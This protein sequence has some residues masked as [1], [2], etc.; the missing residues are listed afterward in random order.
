MD[1]RFDHIIRDG[2][3]FESFLRYVLHNP[4]ESG[5]VDRADEYDAVRVQD[6]LQ[7]LLLKHRSETGATRRE[8]GDN[9]LS[10][11]PDRYA[12]TYEAWHDGLRDWCISRQLW[13][14][15]R[16]PVWTRETGGDV[17]AWE[18]REDCAVAHTEHHVHVCPASDDDELIRRLEEEGFVRDPDVLDTWFSSA[19]WPL[20]TMGWPEGDRPIVNPH[21][22][23]PADAS[24]IKSVW[25][26]RVR[27]FKEFIG[28]EGEY[29]G[30][31][32]DR[33]LH[34][35][36]NATTAD[37]VRPIAYQLFR[38][39]ELR[40]EGVNAVA[41]TEPEDIQEADDLVC[42]VGIKETAPVESTKFGAIHVESLLLSH[43]FTDTAGLLDAFNPSTVL[44]TGRDIIT[45][46]VSRMVM[47]NRYFKGGDLPFRDVYINPIV[48]DG[49]GQR[50]SKS[51]GNGVDPLDIVHSH[52][53]DALRIVLCQIAT[54]TQ[55]VRMPVDT[56]CPHTG[57]VFEP[58]TTVTGAGRVV[59]APIQ[60]SPKNPSKKMVT[61]YGVASGLAEATDETP[62][63]RNTSSRFDAGRNICTK[64]WNATR[65]G[66][67]NLEEVEGSADGPVSL[68]D[69]SLV[70][71]WM[72]GRLVRAVEEID[73]A[74]ATYQ[75]ARYADL[76]YDLFWRDFCDWYLEAVK[77]TLRSDP[78]QRAV[79]RAAID[80]ILRV[81]HPITP[82]I[83][84]V[85]YEHL[86]GLP[87]TGTIDGLT[88]GASELLC[89]APWPVVDGSLY[90]EGV[91]A[92][93]QE[94]QSLVEAIRQLRAQ[95]NITFKQKLTLHAPEP[96]V[97]LV[98]DAGEVVPTLAGLSDVTTDAPEGASVELLHEGVS[99]R[100]SG[101]DE[102]VDPAKLRS[103]LAD[104]EKKLAGEIRGLEGRL[105]NPGYVNKAP[106]HLVEETKGQLASKQ[107]ER[108]EIEQRL[109]DLA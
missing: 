59:A 11:S 97:A 58:E 81:F 49:H 54:A 91:G 30:E 75:F 98:R 99:L 66:M 79:F 23:D 34:L 17:S 109:K 101:L 82:F 93:W 68:D 105:N 44:C 38:E 83:T 50:M 28:T 89:T 26:K 20:S 72:L 15:H 18:Q 33:L 42:A 32:I 14:G 40:A 22:I 104:R 29:S 43:G 86:R 102:G 5:L 62:L 65:F 36:D 25:V 13:W 16:I 57:E 90:D 69:A 4:V 3:W 19:L 96:I 52:G 100:L 56:V 107:A 87:Q 92:R 95:Q 108:A 88:L 1:E 60:T 27:T 70:D 10:F 55:D 45:L 84:E 2:V 74:I 94:V 37:G 61:A 24:S 76:V 85:L 12:K 9:G 64:L 80:V 51:L 71:R 41:L 78:V 77:P 31:L 47:F 21:Q 8:N 53:A 73:E 106:A 7:S 39:A 103:Q 63:A 6:G 67:L 46:W 48:Q 35:R